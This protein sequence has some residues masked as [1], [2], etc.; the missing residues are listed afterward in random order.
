MTRHV[1]F[2]IRLTQLWSGF[3]L[4][5]GLSLAAFAVAAA[6]LMVSTQEQPPGTEVAAGVT[7]ASLAVVSLAAI[8]WALAHHLAARGLRTRKPWARHLALMLAALN[9]LLLPLG[10][11]LGL[12]M[13]WVLL[14][15]Q[16]RVEFHA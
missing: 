16:V 6:M 3:N 4:V 13:L 2:L 12:Y 8:A 14:H 7:A 15:E 1:S 10:T 5:V 9:L 11:A